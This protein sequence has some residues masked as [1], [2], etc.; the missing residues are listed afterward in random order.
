MTIAFSAAARK[1][2]GVLARD[3]AGLTGCG[4][5]SYGAGLIYAPIGFIVA[6]LLLI[7]GAYLLAKAG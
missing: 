5:V 7:A 3:G 2:A 1:K 4:L 6:G